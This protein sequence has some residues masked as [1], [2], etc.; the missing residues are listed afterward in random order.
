MNEIKTVAIIGSGISGLTAA[1]LL[2]ARYDITVYEACN[3]IGGHTNTI[4]VTEGSRRL[5]ID[6]GF[7]VFNEKTYPNFIKLIDQLKVKKQVSNMSFSFSSSS[8]KLEYSGDT[9]SSLFAQRRNL[10]N[11]KF[12]RFLRDIH[13]FNKNAKKIIKSEFNDLSLTD[14]I[15]TQPCGEYFKN[16]YLN[17]LAAAI[18]STPCEEIGNMPARF[19]LDFYH[20]H[21]LLEI[22]N[23]PQWYV[24]QNGSKSYIEALIKPFKHKILLNHPVLQLTRGRDAV[25]ITTPHSKKTYD[26]VVIACHSNQALA[27]LQN[28]SVHEQNI[29]GSIPYINN[30]AILHTDSGA[31][32]RSR[33]AW[34]SWNYTQCENQGQASLTYYMNKLQSI[35]SNTNYYVSLNHPNINP[36]SII[37]TF[38]YDHP[39]YN[40]TSVAAKQQHHI[41]NN[42]QRTFYTGAYWGNGFHEDG[43]KSSLKALVSLGVRL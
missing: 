8:T 16:C 36:K 32:P 3:Y 10:L 5:A 25:T 31:M 42:K 40:H 28:P 26:A 29:L 18:W 12:Y 35:N 38:Q 37:K 15:S 7:I 13:Q 19:L 6:S 23:R 11:P 27:L 9:V 41:I 1:H 21:G 24:I 43:V 39:L 17:P 14:F 2:Q 22:K 30:T 20:N 33:R 34:A 4:D